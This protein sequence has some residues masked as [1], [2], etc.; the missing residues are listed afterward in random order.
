MSEASSNRIY[1]CEQNTQEPLFGTADTV[2]AWVLLEYKPVWRPKALADNSLDEATRSWLQRNLDELAAAGIKARPQFIRRPEID[3]DT[4]QLFVGT[5][6]GLLNLS[7]RGYGFLESVRLREL[8]EAA[9]AEHRVTEPRYFVCTN[10]QRDVCCARYGLPIYAGLRERVGARAWQIT[11]LGGHRFAPNVLTLPQAALYGRLSDAALDDFVAQVEAG[12]LDFDHL[13]GRS[14]LPPAAQA[15]EAL[16][17][18]SDLSLV[19]SRAGADGLI[20]V[21]FEGPDG[22]LEVPVRA[23]PSVQVLKSCDDPAPKP[24]TPFQRA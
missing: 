20:T 10:G 6:D 16:A 7:G 23:G 3:S 15:A 8:L 9:P 14:R 19:D 2:D 24:V 1:C 22:A 4:V 11:H 18:R 21:R 5:A 12:E 13:R 17:G